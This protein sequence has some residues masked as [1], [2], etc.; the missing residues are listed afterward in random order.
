MSSSTIKVKT[1]GEYC[2]DF[3][4]TSK[5]QYL[6]EGLTRVY[7]FRL[8]DLKTGL[9]IKQGTSISEFINNIENDKKIEKVYFHNLSF[10]GCFIIDYLLRNDYKYVNDKEQ[11]SKENCNS[12]YSIIDES[13]SIY[14]IDIY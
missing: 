9:D 10:D 14:E 1:K 8:V 3:E 5:N 12:F 11:L 2:C 7:L 13:G 4:T 6:K